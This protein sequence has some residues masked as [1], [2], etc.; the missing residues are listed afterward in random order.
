[1]K[2]EDIRKKQFF[3]FDMD[4]TLVDLEEMN[5]RCF[6]DTAKEL[7]LQELTF[8]QYMHFFAGVGSV[9]GF[10]GYIEQL[11]PRSYTATELV[12]HYRAQKSNYL[13]T[14]FDEV[15]TLIDGAM[16]FLQRLRA[17][18]KKL[19]VGT[20]TVRVF[21]HQILEKSGLAQYFDAIIS[22]DDVVHSKPAPDIFNKALDAIQGTKEKAVIFE[23]SGN[24]VKSAENSEMDFIVI[25][26]KGKNDAVVAGRKNVIS[27]YT[28]LLPFLE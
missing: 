4:G 10:S 23:D 16:D 3:L 2:L 15:V 9:K 1:M 14:R 11:N 17:L 8:E 18:N 20:S 25:H 6:R 22:V 12:A 7:L 27:T 5:Y 21:A 24:G 13:A 19:A 26:N 28:A